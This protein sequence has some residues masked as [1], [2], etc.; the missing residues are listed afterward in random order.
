M[1]Q[2]VF[3]MR[4]GTTWSMDWGSLEKA[5]VQNMISMERDV[6][7]YSPKWMGVIYFLA[8]IKVKEIMVEQGL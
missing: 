6:V 5:Q 4:G 8:T 3:T 1:V 7:D 2:V